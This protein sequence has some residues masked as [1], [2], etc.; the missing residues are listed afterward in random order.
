MDFFGSEE[1]HFSKEVECDWNYPCP[2]N[3]VP[4]ILL[5]EQPQAFHTCTNEQK[6]NSTKK[7]NDKPRHTVSFSRTERRRPR[8]SLQH[9]GVW[10][11]IS[12]CTQFSKRNHSWEEDGT[13]EN[14]GPWLC[15]PWLNHSTEKNAICKS[16]Q[17]YA[18][19]HSFYCHLSGGFRLSN[20]VF[21]GRNYRFT[22]CINTCRSSLFLG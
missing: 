4:K 7:T 18:V 16:Y 5:G 15:G 9:D 20:F 17:I 19:V 22:G 3:D 12:G 10:W 1:R 14:Y 6:C 11:H 2:T 21:D 13:E 8:H